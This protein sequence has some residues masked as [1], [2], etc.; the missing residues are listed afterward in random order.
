MLALQVRLAGIGVYSGYWLA[1]DS[2]SRHIED[3]LQE[4]GLDTLKRV[5]EA[6]GISF[7]GSHTL[8][9]Q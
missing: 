7:T 6:A 1:V 8:D 2:P 4:E 3:P 9:V 5:M